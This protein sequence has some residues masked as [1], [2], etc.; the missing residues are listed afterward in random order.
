MVGNRISSIWLATHIYIKFVDACS[1][2]TM[3]HMQWIKSFIQWFHFED[4]F[5]VAERN[6]AHLRNVQD[7]TEVRFN[8]QF[9]SSLLCHLAFWLHKKGTICIVKR[10]QIIRRDCLRIYGHKLIKEWKVFYS[11]LC[12]ILFRSDFFSP[13]G[14]WFSRPDRCSSN[15]IINEA[16]GSIQLFLHKYKW[17][18]RFNFNLNMKIIFNLSQNA[19]HNNSR[20]FS[21]Y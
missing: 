3:F 15:N 5:L 11:S 12:A 4:N 1:L 7:I 9:S 13:W 8:I 21:W 14:K 19:F 10:L 6:L 17:E 2:K 18:K 16:F 20:L